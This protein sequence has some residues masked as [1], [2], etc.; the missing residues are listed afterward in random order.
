[1]SADWA[2]TQNLLLRVDFAT[3]VNFNA[4]GMR[5][6]TGEPAQNLGGPFHVDNNTGIF[7]AT[8]ESSFGAISFWNV[9][10]DWL[11]NPI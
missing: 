5:I 9:A 4:R 7:K 6:F 2:L 10:D 8:F 11:K 3:R 1:M